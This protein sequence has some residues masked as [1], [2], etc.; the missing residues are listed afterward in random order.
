MITIRAAAYKGTKEQPLPIGRLGENCARE[1]LFELEALR[2]MYGSG[3]WKIVA[4]QPYGSAAYMVANQREED[5]MAIW[6]ISSVDAG[7]CGLG[8]VELRYY[9]DNEDS[10]LYKTQ[11]WVTRIEN[12]LYEYMSE[13]SPYGDIIDQMAGTLEELE[14]K[15]DEAVAAAKDARNITVEVTRSEYDALS[16]D[17]KNDG[18][19]YLITDETPDS[20]VVYEIDTGSEYTHLYANDNVRLAWLV[21]DQTKTIHAENAG[22]LD[23]G[24]IIEAYRP[25]K[26]VSFPVTYGNNGDTLYTASID[27]DTGT[28]NMYVSDPGDLIAVG[29][30]VSYFYK[31]E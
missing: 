2:E 9:P 20:R 31:G 10:S 18:T 21:V 30:A 19:F 13:E 29:G 15:A 1:V 25:L 22:Y 6:T 8:L 23:L 28:I 12:S 4:K 17:L 14:K 26:S 5:S 3:S 24:S 11:L 16:D 27:A 7:A